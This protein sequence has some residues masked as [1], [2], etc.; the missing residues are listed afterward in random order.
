MV[1]YGPEDNH[2]VVELTYNYGLK[3][4]KRGNDFQVVCY[5]LAMYLI[6][7]GSCDCSG[8]NVCLQSMS[9]HSKGAVESARTLNWKTLQVRSVSCV[10][11]VRCMYTDRVCTYM[12]VMC[13][14]CISISVHYLKGTV[15]CMCVPI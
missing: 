6:T 13:M 10:M 9:I 4:Y 1:G 7:C 3:A 5:C 15:V 14:L 11:N 2:F 12:S 8:C